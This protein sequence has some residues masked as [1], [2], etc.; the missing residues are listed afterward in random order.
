MLI[1]GKDK[2]SFE[3]TVMG[4]QFPDLVNEQYDSDW[5]N[6]KINVS[7]PK[8][9][10]TSTDPSLL[11]W[12][13]VDLSKWIESI[14]EG[15]SVDTEESFMEPNLR[16]ELIEAGQKKIRIYFSLESKP[17]WALKNDDLWADF[18]VATDDLEKA[19]TSLREDLTRFPTRVGI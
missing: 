5:L 6:I 8:G 2:S 1:K 19:A 17:S 16:F 15:Q 4:Y 9:S 13:V 3:M 18:E 11:T 10:W 12:E 14:A 7:I